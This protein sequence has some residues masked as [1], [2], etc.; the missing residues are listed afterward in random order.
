M[1]SSSPILKTWRS[2]KKFS[3]LLYGSPILKVRCYFFTHNTT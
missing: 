3:I 1:L 2:K